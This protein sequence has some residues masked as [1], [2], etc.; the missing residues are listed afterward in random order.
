MKSL[1]ELHSDTSIPDSKALAAPGS[2]TRSFDRG[3]FQ[4]P[5]PIPSAFNTR[6]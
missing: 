1:K 3:D 5:S 6:R 2:H 4:I